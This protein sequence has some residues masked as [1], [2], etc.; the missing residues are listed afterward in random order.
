M[1]T[2][3]HNG[4]LVIAWMIGLAGCSPESGDVECCPIGG[5]CDEYYVGGDKPASGECE[6]WAD[7]LEARE[8]EPTAAGCRRVEPLG[9]KSCFFWDSGLPQD[10]MPA[11]APDAADSTTDAADSTTDARSDADTSGSDSEDADGG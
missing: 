8:K 5:N 10:T 9:G 1:R 3:A 11:D 6:V 2:T 7:L 4:A